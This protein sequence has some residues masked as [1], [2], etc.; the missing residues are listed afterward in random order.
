[1]AKEKQKSAAELKAE[2]D[3]RAANGLCRTCIDDTKAD[4]RGLCFR[5]IRVFYRKRNAGELTEEAAEAAGLI[6]PRK[7]AKKGASGFEKALKLAKVR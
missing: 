6:S 4:V 3:T 1:M 5:D 2:R 7:R